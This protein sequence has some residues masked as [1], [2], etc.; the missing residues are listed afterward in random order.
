[1]ERHFLLFHADRYSSFDALYMS[2][3]LSMIAAGLVRTGQ[4]NTLSG[5][6]IQLILS[7]IGRDAIDSENVCGRW[8][9]V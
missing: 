1:M 3:S 5:A 6:L 7:L 2:L 8:G 9:D 4:E